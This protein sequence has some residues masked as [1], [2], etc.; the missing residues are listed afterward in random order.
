ML[1]LRQMPDRRRPTTEP[2][3]FDPK[4][5][6]YLPSRPFPPYRFIQGVTPHPHLDPRSPPPLA[7][8]RDEFLYAVDLYNFN[9]WWEAHESWELLW[10]TTAR[11]DRAG[12]FFQGLIQISAGMIKWWIGNEE[13]MR[14]LF[15]EG[16]RRLRSIKEKT[17]MGLDLTTHLTKIERFLNQ[18]A[19]GNYPFIEL[20]P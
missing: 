8:G 12:Q 5:Q 3:P 11:T 2:S 4:R 7:P 18:P 13:G 19:K 6:R 9:Y 16:D 20:A 15:G 10:K 1:L 14:Q 17:F